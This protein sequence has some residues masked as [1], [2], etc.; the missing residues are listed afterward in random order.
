[1]KLIS[2]GEIYGVYKIKRVSNKQNSRH[3]PMFDCQCLEC[4]RTIPLSWSALL[5]NSKTRECICEIVENSREIRNDYKYMK[6]HWGEVCLCGYC[7]HMFS[8]V[9]HK[10]NAIDKRFMKKYSIEVVADRMRRRNVILVYDCTK[11]EF[12]WGNKCVN[13]KNK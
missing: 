8:C 12:D 2:I 4:G 11:F 5:K 6:R 13:L 3:M 7:K 10:F 9:R 1:M